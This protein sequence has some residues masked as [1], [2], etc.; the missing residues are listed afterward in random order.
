MTSSSPVKFLTPEEIATRQM[1]DAA[2]L[3]FADL[4]FVFKDRELRLRQLAAGHAM[5]DFLIFMADVAQAQHAALAAPRATRLPSQALLDEAAGAGVPPLEYSR[6]NCG[7]E[8][9]ADLHSLLSTLLAR[10]PPGPARE[11]VE[12]LQAAN[13]EHWNRQAARLLAGIML[14]L[15]FATAPLIGAALQVYWTRLVA[16]TQAAFPDQA[17]AP[18]DNARVCPCC[19]SQPVASVSRIGGDTSGTRYLHCALC[20]TEW[21][22]VRIKCAHCESTKGITY[23]ELEAASGAAL[24]ATMVPKGAVR[25][26]CCDACGHYLKI[27]SMDKD[28]QVDPVADDLATVTLDLLVSETGKIRHGINYMLL[29]GEPADDP[30][31]REHEHSG[32][33]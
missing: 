4:A 27:V 23:Q 9:H 19:G 10:L 1:A 18:V 29:W 3:K 2:R 15:D 13:S 16:R 7:D 11:V 14:G 20:Q 32:V 31:A 30:Q 8:W 5:R 21:H 25:A 33:P 17:F 24:P 28:P 6:W 12:G 22:M 26:E